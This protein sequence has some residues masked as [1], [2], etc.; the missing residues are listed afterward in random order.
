MDKSKEKVKD[1]VY[2]QLLNPDNIMSERVIAE[3][4]KVKRS[5]VREILLG[6][7]GGGI[8]ERMPQRG[9]RCV[10][11]RTSCDM[12]S[13]CA[14]RF[15]LEREAL[16]AAMDSITTNDIVRAG[17]ILEEMDRHLELK[18]FTKFTEDDMNFHMALIQ[19]SCNN[20]LIRMFSFMTSTVFRMRRHYDMESCLI[21]QN[22]HR[23]LFQHVK[24][25][26]LEGAIAILET[27]VNTC[28]NKQEPI[29]LENEK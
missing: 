4:F 18:D 6:M 27:H 15:T 3:K 10:D 29:K 21:T 17:L 11:Y 13:I 2:S 24:K 5:C 22:E 12:E 14:V 9:Y 19:A 16:R 20:L 25:R 8:L 26:D 23:Q 7:E 28:L 1:Y